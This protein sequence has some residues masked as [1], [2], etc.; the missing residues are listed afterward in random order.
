MDKPNHNAINDF[1]DKC[2]QGHLK[3]I[4]HQVVLLLVGKG[5]IS[6]K[7][8]FVDGTKIEAYSNRYTFVWGNSKQIIKLNYNLI[9]LKSK[10]RTLL[11]IG[12]GIAK[13]KHRYWD[14]EAVFGNIKQNLKFNLMLRNRQIKCRN[15]INYNGSQTKKV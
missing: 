13:R 5:V 10:A 12:Q 2:L 3:K 1:R 4:F 7:D 14:V 6:L 15:R 9:R 11:L 8:I